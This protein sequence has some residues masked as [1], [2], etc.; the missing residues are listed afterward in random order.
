[1]FVSEDDSRCLLNAPLDFSLLIDLIE[2]GVEFRMVF[3]A[4][5][6]APGPLTRFRCRWNGSDL[7]F[8]TLSVRESGVF[9]E[10]NRSA[11]NSAVKFLC[12]TRPSF[13]S[14]VDDFVDVEASR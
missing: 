11:V 13:L 7:D 3:P 9:A 4:A 8:D 10:F 12:H 2:D 14:V 6:G 5:S 1:M